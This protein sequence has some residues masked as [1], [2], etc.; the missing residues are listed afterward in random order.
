MYLDSILDATQSF[1]FMHVLTLK[2]QHTSALKFI[3]KTVREHLWN[4][5]W[6]KSN[7]IFDLFV[8]YCTK[9]LENAVWDNPSLSNLV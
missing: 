1:V 8:T 9:I 7:V 6:Q 3:A 5:D 2:F 4:E